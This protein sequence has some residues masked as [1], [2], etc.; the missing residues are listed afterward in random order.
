MPAEKPLVYF[1]LGAAGS[2]RREV[3]ADLIEGGLSEDKRAAVLLSEGEDSDSADP[4]LGTVGRWRWIAAGAIEAA[5]P[6]DLDVVFLITDGRVNP[7]D[8]LE[9]FKAWVS[10]Q[11]VELARILT[12]VDCRLAE[13]NPPLLAW[14]DACVHFSDVV[15]L[16]RRDGVANKWISGFQNRIKHQFIPCLVE[17]VKDGRV[18]NPALILEPQALRISHVFDEEEDWVTV[19]GEDAEAEDKEGEGAGGEEEVEMVP[20]EDPYFARRQGGRRVKELPDIA[21]FLSRAH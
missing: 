19:D 9:A 11:S 5:V 10:G 14:Y 12:V 1:I 20:E 3:V 17:L 18:A 4:R 6:A 13:L 16:N 21:E 15:L 8:Q 2:G 7:V